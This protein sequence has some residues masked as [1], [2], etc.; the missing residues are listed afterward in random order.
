MEK[1]KKDIKLLDQCIKEKWIPLYKE[2]GANYGARNCI[3]CKEYNFDHHCIGCPIREHT[4]FRY[5]ARTPYDALKN[6]NG[7]TYK[8]K[9][10]SVKK[11]LI[12]L[13]RLCYML[14]GRL[15]R[16]LMIREGGGE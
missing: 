5:C 14:K 9:N 15:A 10:P 12:F 3:L 8:P 11:E 2:G 13:I 4:T 16:D 1:L 6:F 7:G